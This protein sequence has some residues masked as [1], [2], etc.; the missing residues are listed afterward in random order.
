MSSHETSAARDVDGDVD[1][2]A[3]VQNAVGQPVSHL[4]LE[5]VE[6]G[7]VFELEQIKINFRKL[8]L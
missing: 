4:L 1:V 2:A 8:L 6:V 3:D 7:C 5:I